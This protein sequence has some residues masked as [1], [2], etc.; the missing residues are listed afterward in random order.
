MAIIEH[1]CL[2]M[3]SHI[4]LITI[5]HMVISQV[6]I[7]LIKQICLMVDLPQWSLSR[8]WLMFHISSH[9]HLT[10]TPA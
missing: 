6:C 2:I 1:I 8:S 4:L 5:G 3:I 7:F 9:M 10:C